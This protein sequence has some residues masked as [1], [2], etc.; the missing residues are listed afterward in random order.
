MRAGCRGA[1]RVTSPQFLIS[2]EPW[3]NWRPPSL[4]TPGCRSTSGC[5]RIGLDRRLVARGHAEGAV[6]AVLRRVFAGCRRERVAVGGA[7]EAVGGAFVAG[8][9]LGLARNRLLLGE[10]CDRVVAL[11]GK[12]VL[13]LRRASE[14]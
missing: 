8:S 7:G 2:S 5:A 9:E 4:R 13:R 6:A 10:V 11:Q 14:H 3:A 1:G 12:V